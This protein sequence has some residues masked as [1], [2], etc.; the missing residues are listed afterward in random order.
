[1][2]IARQESTIQS[3]PAG[4][5]D[6]IKGWLS[7]TEPL[8]RIRTDERVT[9]LVQFQNISGIYSE[10][11]NTLDLNL[12]HGIATIEGPG[13]G[14]LVEELSA[15]KATLIRSGDQAGKIRSVTYVAHEKS[16]PPAGKTAAVGR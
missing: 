11:L 14:E 8:I 7:R 15:H 16:K 3:K 6:R 2:I 1:M 12:G 5:L 9:Y 10:D 4:L 13:T